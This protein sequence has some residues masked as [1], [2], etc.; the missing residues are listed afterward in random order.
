MSCGIYLLKFNG[1]DKV[2]VGQS[3]NIEYRYKKHIQALKRGTNSCKL[4]KE[5]S[6]S[7]EPY[8]EIL[9]VCQASELNECENEAIQ[10]YNSVNNGFNIAE[11]ADIHGEG[12][13]NPASKYSEQ[14]IE[15]V[16]ELLLDLSYKYKDI[17]EKTGVSLSTV[18]HVANLET[19]T[20]LQTKYPDKYGLLKSY[21]GKLRQQSTNSAEQRGI[22]YPPIISTEGKE[23]VVTNVAAFAR[24]HGLDSSSLSKV[25]KR[26]PRY[27]SHKGW[28]LA[29]PIQ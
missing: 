28:K 10:I 9:L 4:Q 24:E 5:Y 25:L 18:R 13:K 23:Y 3:V 19:H 14:Q 7:G 17:E 22:V 1:T 6:Y 27:L 16:F 20:W 15:Q 26:I 2:Y 29:D 12:E 8:L 21:K 11:F